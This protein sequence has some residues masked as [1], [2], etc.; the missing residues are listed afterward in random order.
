MTYGQIVFK[1]HSLQDFYVTGY[2]NVSF[3]RFSMNTL[4]LYYKSKR[5]LRDVL[6]K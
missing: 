1:C 4:Y 3:H 5:I 6:A 2:I